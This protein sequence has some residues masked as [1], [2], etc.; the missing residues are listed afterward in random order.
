MGRK[1][2]RCFS[3]AESVLYLDMCL[4][5]DLLKG[6]PEARQRAIAA[7]HFFDYVEASLNK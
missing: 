1:S 7:S 5:E 4:S 6:M 3:K 2:S